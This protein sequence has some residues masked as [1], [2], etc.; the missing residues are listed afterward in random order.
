M[1]LQGHIGARIKQLRETKK[2]T[3]EELAGLA[4][5][6]A[7]TLS[8]IEAGKRNITVETL[9]FFLIALNVTPKD[10]FG[11]P[12]FSHTLTSNPDDPESIN[13]EHFSVEEV[14]GGVRVHF[15]CGQY[16]AS[17]DFTGL[18]RQKVAQ[19]I[20]LLR[21][22]LRQAEL[23]SQVADDVVAQPGDE[24][25]TTKAL[26]S[27]A[28]A[29]SFLSLIQGNATLNPSDVWRGCVLRVSQHEGAQ[30][31]AAR[32]KSAGGAKYRRTYVAPLASLCLKR[33]TQP[34][35]AAA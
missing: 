6:D 32:R 17:L 14:G 29:E 15:P 19:A 31:R 5:S 16:D 2:L 24:S 25:P 4:R 26:M 18:D 30:R 21:R 22:G 13:S 7:A 33:R 1:S 10:F 12:A 34:P 20:L 11:T 28:L 8:R 27:A 35:G 23:T 9:A 3:Q